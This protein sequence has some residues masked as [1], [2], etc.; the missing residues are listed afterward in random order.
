[1][2]ILFLAPHPFF[3]LR[4]SPIADQAA[5]EALSDQGHEVHVLSYE[6][7]ED[8]DI[9]NVTHHRS[10]YPLGVKE[11]PIGPS[12]QKALCDVPFAWKALQLV[13]REKVDIVHAVEEAAFMAWIIRRL[14][15]T[16]YVFDMDSLMSE[17]VAE[18]SFWYAPA[19]PLFRM[20]EQRSIQRALAVLAVCPA[21]VDEARRHHPDGSLVHLLPDFP[22][23]DRETGELP[24]TL[25]EAPGLKFLYVGNLESYQGIDLMVEGFAKAA[26]DC[27]D[28]TLVV[29]GGRAD[30]IEQY[31]ARCEE[32]GIGD[33]T[34][35]VGPIPATQL[36]AVLD[37]GDVL[38][39]PRI[40]GRNT[41]M[42]VYS[43]LQSGKPTIATRLSTHTQVITEEASLLVEPNPDDFAEGIRR[44]S[45]SPEDRAAFGRRGKELVEAE[46]SE[47]AFRQRLAKFY[48]TVAGLHAGAAA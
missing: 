2:K 40:A 27:P 41:P 3:V 19:V 24:T 6:E 8:V 25:T 11:V 17:Q 42:K 13:K 48:E 5:L 4:G 22:L 45:T 36:Q 14:T 20:L 30:H 46:Y 39:S 18:R 1:M 15:G 47:A 16:P 21:L 44:L 12:W 43:Y 7:G 32:L 10:S 9:P 35:F 37:Q 29:V 33:R 31:K 28:A 38:L 26:P 23:A 34:V